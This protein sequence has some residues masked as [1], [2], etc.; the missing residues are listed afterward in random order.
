MLSCFGETD[1][2]FHLLIAEISQN[3]VVFD[4]MSSLLIYL[5]TYS[6][7]TFSIPGRIRQSALEHEIIFKAIRESDADT[8]RKAMYD[9]INSVYCSLTDSW[10]KFKKF[11]GA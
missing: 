7:Y 4:L 6:R 5:E 9:H 11:N 2:K 3:P 1:R 10:D 8:A